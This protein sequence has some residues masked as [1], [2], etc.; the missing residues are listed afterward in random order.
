MG[1]N[2]SNVGHSVTSLLMETVERGQT[3]KRFLLLLQNEPQHRNHGLCNIL[4][5]FYES[6]IQNSTSKTFFT[7]VEVV[8]QKSRPGTHSESPIEEKRVENT[9]PKTRYAPFSLWYVGTTDLSRV[10]V[11]GLETRRV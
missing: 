11:V 2:G 8:N 3:H 6:S 7:R 4:C 5:V 1:T 9:N 10:G